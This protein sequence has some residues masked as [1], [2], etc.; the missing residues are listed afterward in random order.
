MKF[1][2]APSRLTAMPKWT[3]SPSEVR[4]VWQYIRELGGL[5]PLSD[6]AATLQQL[7]PGLVELPPM[8]QNYAAST[9]PE[10]S[11]LRSII[12]R[13]EFHRR[14]HRHYHV[15]HRVV[16]AVGGWDAV[17]LLLAPIMAEWENRGASTDEAAILL[18]GH[19]PESC[20]TSP[21]GLNWGGSY[22]GGAPEPFSNR[23]HGKREL[24]RTIYRLAIELPL[25]AAWF[26]D[27]VPLASAESGISLAE[28]NAEQLRKR[29]RLENSNPNAFTSGEVSAAVLSASAGPAVPA[30][31]RLPDAALAREMST[32]TLTSAHQTVGGDVP[33]ENLERHAS[34]ERTT[35]DG[36]AAVASNTSREL[37]EVKQ[38]QAAAPRPDAR[39]RSH[40]R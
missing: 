17:V 11:L 9:N 38:Q 12:A 2:C 10:R 32:A 27:V 16:E 4:D 40:E 31:S 34:P 20:R 5:V 21:D 23:K 25:G 15:I 26:A 39:V 13:V 35:N 30:S 22:G 1:N 18:G 29:A 7:H 6:T 36:E 8:P 3:E 24:M 19:V 14:H 33:T 28:N 37:L